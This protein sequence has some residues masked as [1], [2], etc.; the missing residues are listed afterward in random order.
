MS[1]AALAQRQDGVLARFQLR[2]HGVS[3]DVIDGMLERGELVAHERT[4]YVV[5]GAPVTY[6]ARLWMALLAARGALAFATAAHL[7]GLV[8]D[9]PAQVHV[10]IATGR[11][12]HRPYG[13]RLHRG[14]VPRSVLEHRDGLLVTSRSWTLLDHL[15]TCTASDAYRLADRG[16]QRSWLTVAEIDRR[17]A[18]YPGRSGNTRLRQIAARCGDGA[19][20]ESERI[21][22]R[23][24]RRGGVDG[25][26]ANYPLWVDG[27]LVAVLDVA[28]PD[29]RVAIEVDG[30]AYHSDVD[31]F[32]RDR[33]RQNALIALG[34]TVLRFTWA[35]LTQRP[36][37]VIATIERLAMAS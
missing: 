33:R 19:A 25:W 13:V 22:H 10:A 29:A 16:L 8:D 15:G 3:A 36:A 37:Y 30:W 28:F 6:R 35:D 12:V 5:R 31:R 27:A 20:A 11:R 7:W 23:I 24:L 18:E 32:Q 9:E 34:W 17:V 2:E 21:L 26:V 1:W 14:F 4:V